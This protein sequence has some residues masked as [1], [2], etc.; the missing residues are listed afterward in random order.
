[1]YLFP[2]KNFCHQSIVIK[3][4]V[5]KNK[6]SDKNIDGYFEEAQLEYFGHYSNLFAKFQFQVW[7]SGTVLSGQWLPLIRDLVYVCLHWSGTSF[8]KM[9]LNE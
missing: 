4:N 6:I 9:H 3:I 7:L 2:V 5:F 1:M 8:T